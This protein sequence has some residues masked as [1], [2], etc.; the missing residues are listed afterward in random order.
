[1]R[2]LLLTFAT[3]VLI[4]IG[5]FA[6]LWFQPTGSSGNNSVS[7]RAPAPQMIAPATRP[8]EMPDPERIGGAGVSEDIW[9]KVPDEKTGALA[10]E[11]R[12]RRFEP[13]KDGTVD[14]LEPEATFYLGAKSN[15]DGQKLVV[16][17]R[18]GKV[19][20]P[21]SANKRGSLQGA[22]SAPTR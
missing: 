7:G 15:T 21:E 22:G 19:V 11:F 5:F 9:I 14:V 8:V 1:M 13:R 12:A 6:Y 17:G 10:N 16:R 18:S 4:G 2:S 3:I 20:L